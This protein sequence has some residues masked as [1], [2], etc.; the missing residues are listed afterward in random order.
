MIEAAVLVNEPMSRHTTWRI[1]GP[2]DVLAIPSRKEDV[3]V[4][5]EFARQWG[6]PWTVLG[7][8][9]NVL[10]LDGGIR[11]LV[12]KMTPGLNRTI[13]TETRVVCGAG[14]LLPVLAREA[15][16]QRLSGLEFAVGIPASVGGAAVMNAGAQGRS[17]V[18]VVTSVEYLS[19]DGNL[20]TITG[21]DL[22]YGYRSSSLKGKNV[23]VVEVSMTLVQ[24]DPFR[25]RGL[26]DEYL[27]KRRQTQPL[28]LPSAGSV[29]LNLP[30]VSAGALIER[31]G[32]KG[33]Q[34]GG[35]QV[36]EKHGNF[37]V[38]RGGA[39]A[40]EV[41]HLIGEIQRKVQDRFGVFLETEIRVLGEAP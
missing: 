6:V 5:L 9:S 19:D 16:R 40:I 10:V 18:D 7:N 12:I 31:S 13:F 22:D 38:N 23:A 2:A 33:L 27:Q 11:G 29:F 34:K 35:A 14:V 26:T 8:G 25:I 3:R 28:E 36:S 20:A 30:D 32:L 37:I 24:G 4:C 17:M 15:A 1:G 39:T 41:L 21:P